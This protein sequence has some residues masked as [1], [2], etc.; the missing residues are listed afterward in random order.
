MAKRSLL[1]LTL[2]PIALMAKPSGPDV[3]QGDAIFV[4]PAKHT[5]QIVTG[6]QTIINWDE[7]SIDSGETTRFIQPNH[8]SAVLNRVVSGAESHI[9]GSLFANGKVFLV[10]PNGILIGPDATIDTHGFIAST[11]DVLDSE[12]MKGRDLRFL[13]NSEGKVVNLGKIRA[14]DGDIALI[15]RFVENQGLLQAPKGIA[16]LAVGK[17]VL[18]KPSD[19][20]RVFICALSQNSSK[21]GTGIFNSGEIE[22]LKVRL[23][24]DGNP[25]K[26]AINHEGKIDATKT[27]ER[28]GEIYLVA[29]NG[30]VEVNGEICVA[31]GDIRVLISEMLTDL[32][33][34]DEYLGWLLEFQTAYAALESTKIDEKVTSS[35]Q[36]IPDQL[37]YLRIKKNFDHNQRIT[38]FVTFPKTL[39]TGKE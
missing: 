1:A 6:D 23:L 29:E 38:H 26:L 2:L 31:K 7:F 22:A 14:W 3:I 27:E 16:A 4:H 34:Y 15:G 36:V 33:P 17:E 25:Y 24:A 37:H 35:F 32:H 19:E 18:L 28:H 5:M 30:T 9:M 13:G 20:E 10:N 11:L 21:K 39:N 8:S 12:F